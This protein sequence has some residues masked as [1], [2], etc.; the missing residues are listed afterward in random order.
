MICSRQAPAWSPLPTW[1]KTDELGGAAGNPSGERLTDLA[2]RFFNCL[3][4]NE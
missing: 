4:L 2:Q 3:Q 1:L